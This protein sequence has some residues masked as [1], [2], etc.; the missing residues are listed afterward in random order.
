MWVFWIY[1][2]EIKD[3]TNKKTGYGIVIGLPIVLN[4]MNLKVSSEE[5]IDVLGIWVISALILIG[6]I[7]WV[8]SKALDGVRV[9]LLP[10]MC[11]RSPLKGYPFDES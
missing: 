3:G 5:E 9:E 1:Y 7:L 4:L 6:L 2:D 10:P 8:A 11:G